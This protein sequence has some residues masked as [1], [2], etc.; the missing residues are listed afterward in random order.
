M[1]LGTCPCDTNHL[2]DSGTIQGVKIANARGAEVT[3]ANNF[4]SAI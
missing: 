2:A 3:M 4:Q 1:A